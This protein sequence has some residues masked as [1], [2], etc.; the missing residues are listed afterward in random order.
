MPII[1]GR[2]G[3]AGD[4][5]S[6]IARLEALASDLERLGDGKM[7]SPEDLEAAPLLDPYTIGTLAV[8]CLIGGNGG[9]PVLS[10]PVIQTSAIWAMAVDLG[11]ARTYSRFYRLGKAV[12]GDGSIARRDRR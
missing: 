5:A 2:P 7:P 3:V 10:G 12:I 1:I 4:I 11:W 8:P 6:D 9:H